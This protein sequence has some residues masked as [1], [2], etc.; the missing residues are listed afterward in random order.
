MPRR[1][2]KKTKQIKNFKVPANNLKRITH[3]LLKINSKFNNQLN[4]S[5]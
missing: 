2:Y 4:N 5:V 3:I 1:Y